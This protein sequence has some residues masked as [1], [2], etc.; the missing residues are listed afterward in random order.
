MSSEKTQPHSIIIAGAGLA[1]LLAAARLRQAFPSASLLLLEKEKQAGGRLRASEEDCE[2]GPGLGYVT[3]DLQ[4][5]FARSFTGE[6]EVPAAPTL[7]AVGLL[8]GQELRSLSGQNLFSEETARILGG[9]VAAKQWKELASFW[10]D[11][12]NFTALGK[13]LPIGKKD[14]FWDVL[15]ASSFPLGI[16]DIRETSIASLIDRSRYF[17]K[18]LHPAPWK[19]SIE[20]LL[21]QHTLEFQSEQTIIASSYSDGL[22]N[23]RTGKGTFTSKALLVAQPPWEATSWLQREDCP[24][25][26]LSLALKHSPVSLLTLSLRFDDAVS[27]PPRLVLPKDGVQVLKITERELCMQV[28]IDFET[29][30]DAPGVVSAVKRLKRARKKICRYL[31]LGDAKDE[32][33][34][35]RPVGWAQ[36]TRAGGRKFVEGFDFAH[37]NRPHLAFCGDSYGSSYDPDQNLIK[38]LLAACSTIKV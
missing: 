11:E 10:E 19:K 5:F 34:A 23:L 25:S 17:A 37:F 35:L 36:D 8:L 29:F 18:G 7:E 15:E 13:A 4:E 28:I 20:T 26:F 38:S 16:V 6:D 12:K 30:L 9:A 24:P 31:G 2:W 22:W 14:P 21:A 32:F 3:P 33:L 27:C 1:G